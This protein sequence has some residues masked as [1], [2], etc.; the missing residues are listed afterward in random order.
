MAKH[1]SN[2]MVCYRLVKAQK[3]HPF[4]GLYGVEKVII[5]AGAIV[6]KELVHEWDL[7]IIA[8]SVLSK[9]GGASA[10]EAYTYDNGEP[11]DLT[12]ITSAPTIPA[13][14]EEDLKDLTK[15]K[16]AKELKGKE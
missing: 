9:L 3:G 11:E 6:S 12:G 16:L 10:Y 8:E 1:G 4:A 14:S 15:R 2:T 5:K 13:R 7:R